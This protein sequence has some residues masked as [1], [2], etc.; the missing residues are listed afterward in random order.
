MLKTHMSEMEGCNTVSDTYI[1][2][3]NGTYSNMYISERRKIV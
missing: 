3:A 1:K 2:F